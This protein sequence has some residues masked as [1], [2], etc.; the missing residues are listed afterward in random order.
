[1]KTKRITAT[2]TACFM[3]FVGLLLSMTLL[4]GST[5]RIIAGLLF[6]I[7]CSLCFFLTLRS[8]LRE[9]S[10]QRDEERS[11][12]Q[13][14]QREFLAA[15]VES[16]QKTAAAFTAE[17]TAS[18]ELLRAAMIES[19]ETLSR[20]LLEIRQILDTHS[21]QL[22]SELV[23]FNEAYRALSEANNQ[24]IIDRLEQ[25]GADLCQKTD[26]LEKSNQGIRSIIDEAVNEII[27]ATDRVEKSVSELPDC[28]RPDIVELEGILRTM[29]RK[30][31]EQTSEMITAIDGL[32][33]ALTDSKS[34]I[35][36]ALNQHAESYERTMERYASITEQDV[37]M[38][39]SVFGAKRDD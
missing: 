6:G 24:Q 36:A 20:Q 1:M 18:G 16:R 17:N 14:A 28:V 31:N 30:Q 25:T 10:A 19:T 21:A 32:S 26:G 27:N 23:S 29:Q 35:E 34:G 37:R 7:L 22:K 4:S 12:L 38:L 9:M 11:M 39:E 3:C 8:V 15:I 5:P 13:K 33:E 2:G